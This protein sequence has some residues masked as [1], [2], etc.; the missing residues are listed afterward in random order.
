VTR[1]VRLDPEAA[2]NQD[3]V[4]GPAPPAP[5]RGGRDAGVD[6]VTVARPVPALLPGPGWAVVACVPVAAP[7]PVPTVVA[8][9][10]PRR[11]RLG[12]AGVVMTMAARA[13]GGLCLPGQRRGGDEPGH[14]QGSHGGGQHRRQMKT[15]AHV[16]PLPACPN[17]PR[18]DTGGPRSGP[19]RPRPYI[20]AT[21]A[22]AQPSAVSG[23]T[24]RTGRRLPSGFL[25]CP[26]IPGR[27][28]AILAATTTPGQVGERRLACGSAHEDESGS[29]PG[30]GA[31][32]A[33]RAGVGARVWSPYSAARPDRVSRLVM[34]GAVGLSRWTLSI[35]ISTPERL[36]AASLGQ[37]PPQ[38]PPYTV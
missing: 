23:R 6:L 16:L 37:A 31:S 22:E 9:A 4:S 32:V 5:C 8:L 14:E 17:D 29:R 25:P 7:G 36:G 13:R 15:E 20:G 19:L 11:P 12:R 1:P 3:P 18:A 33:G 2:S 30:R 10:V 38:W 34:A 21:F 26:T 27:S 28:P 35:G 24:R